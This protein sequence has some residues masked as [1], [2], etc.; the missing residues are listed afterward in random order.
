MVLRNYKF[1][2]TTSGKRILKNSPV[3]L[4]SGDEIVFSEQVQKFCWTFNVG[5]SK[6]KFSSQEGE[7]PFKKQRL[8]SD[9]QFNSQ[10]L[11]NAVLEVKKVAAV[12]ILREKLYIYKMQR[13]F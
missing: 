2:N 8:Q 6:R 13:M 7:Q 3:A 9:P 4:E 10:R 12:R 11:D 5:E 1:Q